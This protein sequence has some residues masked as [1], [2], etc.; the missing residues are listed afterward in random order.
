MRIE[1]CWKLNISG[2]LRQPE[3]MT[4]RAGTFEDNVWKFLI[5][6]EILFH[7]SSVFICFQTLRNEQSH[8]FVVELILL[9]LQELSDT[10]YELNCR[11]ISRWI[12]HSRHSLRKFVLL[13]KKQ[14]R[15]RRRKESK[16]KQTKKYLFLAVKSEIT[17]N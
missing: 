4:L 12:E 11:I 7:H 10:S 9:L 1:S 14:K 16:R 8:F 5:F 2:G 17:N 15:R 3:E 6:G 13:T